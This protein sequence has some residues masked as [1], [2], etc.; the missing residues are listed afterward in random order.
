MTVQVGLVDI[1]VA[2]LLVGLEAEVCLLVEEVNRESLSVTEVDAESTSVMTVDAEILAAAFVDVEILSA[3]ELGITSS[4]AEV[5][6][7][8]LLAVEV[9]VVS[10][11]AADVDGELIV[12]RIEVN[13]ILQGGRHRP[14]VAGP[15]PGS[16]ICPSTLVSEQKGPEA[17]EPGANDG[18][19]QRYGQLSM[20]AG[21]IWHSVQWG[22]SPRKGQGVGVGASGLMLVQ[23]ALEDAVLVCC[24]QYIATQVVRDC[25][26]LGRGLQ[27]GMR[28]Y[29]CSPASRSSCS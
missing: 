28:W 7:E 21:V 12:R 23:V 13:D 15:D 9:N 3:V 4:L 16:R 1:K 22:L 24:G 18:C 17:S 26:D 19:W 6:V 25:S 2:A 27:G 29:L 10:L 11:S 8:S 5:D 14:H 20:P